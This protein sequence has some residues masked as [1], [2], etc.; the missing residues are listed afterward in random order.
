MELADHVQRKCDGQSAAVRPPR[1]P[2]F[3]AVTWPRTA[4]SFHQPRLGFVRV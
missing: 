3:A 1:I 2:W 4:V